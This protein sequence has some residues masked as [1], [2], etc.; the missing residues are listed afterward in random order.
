M[1]VCGCI[2]LLVA[3]MSI[4]FRSV[5]FSGGGEGGVVERKWSLWYFCSGPFCEGGKTDF[6]CGSCGRYVQVK[7]SWFPAV[8]AQVH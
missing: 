1:K 4:L 3:P 6:V 7:L 5:L 2:N 8:F